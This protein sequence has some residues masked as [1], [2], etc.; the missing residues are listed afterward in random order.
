MS[1]FIHFLFYA[2]FPIH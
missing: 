1:T 2:V